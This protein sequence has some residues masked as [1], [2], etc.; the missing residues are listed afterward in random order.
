M[1]AGLGL[2]SRVTRFDDDYDDYDEYVDDNE[3]Y[4][5]D[6]NDDDLFII[7]YVVPLQN[8]QIGLK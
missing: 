1:W 4:V 7:V 3:N 8:S 2:Q 6:N 5:V